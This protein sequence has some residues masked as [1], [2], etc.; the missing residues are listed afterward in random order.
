ME[1]S[2][3]AGFAGRVAFRHFP[4]S[5]AALAAALLA[6]CTSDDPIV[7]ETVPKDSEPAPPVAPAPASAD[8]ML[9]AILPHG[10]AAWFFKM[11]GPD[12]AVAGSKAVFLDLIKSVRFEGGQPKW[13]LPEGWSERGGNAMRLS[14][15]VLPGDPPLEIAVSSLPYQADDRV[16][17]LLAN[18]NRWR[19]QMGLSP[20]DAERLHNGG[21]LDDE[22]QELPLTD[23]TKATL[24]SFKG[25]FESGGMTPPF[26]GGGLAPPAGSV[27][28]RSTAPS[29]IGYDLPE[30]WKSLGA[31]G[32]SLATFTADGEGGT[33]KV[34][35][36]PLPAS[37]D[38]VA[39]VSR[40]RDQVGLPSA[41]PSEIEGT[42]K[43]VTLGDGEEAKYVILIGPEGTDPRKAILGVMAVRNDTA[44][45]VK[46]TGTAEAALR[47]QAAFESFVKTLRLPKDG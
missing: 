41:E 9:A 14:T 22:T 26:A 36:T 35:T 46:L 42:L 5:A 4:A 18:V 28:P 27:P 10:D 21:G 30:G 20:I 31:D 3:L 23:G 32:I 6:G 7:V 44:W 13:T 15:L 12:S 24:V 34:T 2:R 11:T 8:R 39:N 25:Q 47:E 16:Q 17:F 43:T 19:G 40:W 37:N 45:F 33:I 1:V 29:P 38:V